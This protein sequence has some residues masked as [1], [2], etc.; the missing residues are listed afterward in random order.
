MPLHECNICNFSSSRLADL[1]RH[2]KT[3]KHIANAD[4]ILKES[5]KNKKH[6][7]VDDCSDNKT[8]S[9]SFSCTFCSKIF[10]HLQSK[11]RHEK[12]YCKKKKPD[13]SSK[14]EEITELK[15]QVKSLLDLVATTTTNFMGLMKDNTDLASKSV[16]TTSYVVKHFDKAP[17]IKKLGNKK[18]IKLLEYNVPKNYTPGDMIIFNQKSDMLDKYLGNIIV[19]EYKTENPEDQSFWNSDSVRL[20]FVVREVLKSGDDEWITDK[21][22]IKL[23][24]LIITPMLD[25]VKDI[26]KEYVKKHSVILGEDDY[27]NPDI[28]GNL[29]SANDIITNINKNTLHTEILRYIAPH[30]NLNIHK[31][32]T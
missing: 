28:V 21:S 12:H 15:Q 14:D 2:K 17:P 6:I 7:S 3:K 13:V 4:K 23:T 11:C 9:E 5:I 22:G 30:F 1:D 19:D 10:T 26:M 18:A 20:S 25:T 32:K 24:T 31:L 29:T 8:L 27:E 16:S